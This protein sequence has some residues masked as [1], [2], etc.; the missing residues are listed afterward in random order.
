MGKSIPVEIPI[1]MFSPERNNNVKKEE[2]NLHIIKD[3][4]PVMKDSENFR[5]KQNI[6]KNN[7][8]S[9]KLDMGGVHRGKNQEQIVKPA[10]PKNW[11][12]ELTDQIQFA[13]WMDEINDPFKIDDFF[14]KKKE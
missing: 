12:D 11:S 8:S 9:K 2:N 1:P 3:E 6:L 13:S 7:N 5:E 10:K 14:V 4:K